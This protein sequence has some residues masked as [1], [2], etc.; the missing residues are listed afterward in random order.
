MK[1]YFS[2]FIFY[3]SLTLTLGLTGCASAHFP[4]ATHDAQSHN[5]SM[6]TKELPNHV[7][8]PS[9]RLKK[10]QDGINNS[11]GSTEYDQLPIQNLMA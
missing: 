8:H 11:E 2:D 3:T 7:H 1:I 6:Q 4:W 10:P 9:S 5:V